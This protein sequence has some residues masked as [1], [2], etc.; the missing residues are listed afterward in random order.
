[1]MYVYYAYIKI[2][3]YSTLLNMFE[4][5]KLHKLFREKTLHGYLNS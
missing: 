4:I 3:V 5:F 2:I 1:M